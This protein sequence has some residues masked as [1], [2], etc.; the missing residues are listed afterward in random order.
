LLIGN[1]GCLDYI[2]ILLRLINRLFNQIRDTC[3]KGLPTVYANR[4]SPGAQRNVTEKNVPYHV[5][6]PAQQQVTAHPLRDIQV[7]CAQIKGE[8]IEAVSVSSQGKLLAYATGSCDL[9]VYEAGSSATSFMITN[10]F[11][12]TIHDASFTSNGDGSIVCS[13]FNSKVAV[14][15]KSGTLMSAIQLPKPRRLNVCSDGTIYVA[16]RQTGIYQSTNG[17]KQFRHVFTSQDN[18]DFWQVIRVS[19]T[20]QSHVFWALKLLKNGSMRLV[21]YTVN[22]D[23]C[24]DNVQG[25]D[26]AIP[27]HVDLHNAAMAFDR[28]RNLVYITDRRNRAVH[29][30]SVASEQYECQL[31]SP[32]HFSNNR[33]PEC[34]TVNNNMMYVGQSNNI[35]GVFIL[36]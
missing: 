29:A 20:P 13:L 31:L 35:V 27:P 12:C 8:H 6:A 2:T 21:V 3:Y 11:S 5:T 4:S 17:G 22:T 16:D 7:K 15:S 1:Y 19:S 33:S 14:I 25:R 23:R 9:H 28:R 18:G 10:P 24:E 32:Q 36:P 34:L 30:L 26:I